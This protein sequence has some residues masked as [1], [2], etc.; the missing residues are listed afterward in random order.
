MIQLRRTCSL[1]KRFAAVT[2]IM[3]ILICF[4]AGMVMAGGSG[5]E[6]GGSSGSPGWVVTDS[7]K[8]WNFAVLAILLIVVIRKFGVADKLN[9]RITGIKE[10]LADLETKRKEAKAKLAEYDEKISSLEAEAEKILADYVKQGEEAKAKILEE[11]ETAAEKLEEQ[12]HRAIEHE[13]K[14]AKDKLQKEITE[15][16]LDKAEEIIKSK[17]TSEDQDRLVDEYLTKVV[18]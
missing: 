9:S 17:I 14:N 18:A 5:D 15:K 1:R 10:Q 13:F 2:I 6:H 11:A 4:S 8:V 16:A 12:A 7:Y 3:A